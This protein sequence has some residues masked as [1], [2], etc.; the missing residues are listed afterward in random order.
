MGETSETYRTHYS[1][2]GAF[3]RREADERSTGNPAGDDFTTYQWCHTLTSLLEAM[4]YAGF[5]S[6]K[7]YETATGKLEC[8]QLAGMPTGVLIL[9]IK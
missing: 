4:K 8:K 1:N 5:S 7:M 9:A 3:I 6:I 2:E